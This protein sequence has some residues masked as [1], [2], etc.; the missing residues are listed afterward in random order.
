MLTVLEENFNKANDCLSN[1][2]DYDLVSQS[3]NLEPRVD[4]NCREFHE[5]RFQEKYTKK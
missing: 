1:F 3:Q 2:P 4:F 5:P